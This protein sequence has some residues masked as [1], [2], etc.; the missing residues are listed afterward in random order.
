[1]DDPDKASELGSVSNPWG[2]L[3]SAWWTALVLG[4]RGGGDWDPQVHVWLTSEASLG[5]CGEGAAGVSDRTWKGPGFGTAAGGPAG[6][7]LENLLPLFFQSPDTHWAAGT[8]G[9]LCLRVT[10]LGSSLHAAIY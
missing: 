8:P 1:M 3:S 6:S 4:L 7:T 2:D 9:L 10:D 5:S